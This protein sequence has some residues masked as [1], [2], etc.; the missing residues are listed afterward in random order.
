M[1][2][3]NADIKAYYRAYDKH[4]PD[5]LALHVAYPCIIDYSP[6]PP[7]CSQDYVMPPWIP[8]VPDEPVSVGLP[9]TLMLM[10]LGVLVAGI[11]SLRRVSG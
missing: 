1:I 5:S 2:I 10:L 4:G 3:T 7:H 9:N 8:H 6:M 11:V